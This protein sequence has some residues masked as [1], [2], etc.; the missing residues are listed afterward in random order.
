MC[1]VF[2][3]Y[4]V[5]FVAG[6]FVPPNFLPAQDQALVHHVNSLCQ[7]FSCNPVLLQT[8]DIVLNETHLVSKQLQPLQGT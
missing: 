1:I 7:R 3:N 4:R 8:A 2:L 5:G 6:E